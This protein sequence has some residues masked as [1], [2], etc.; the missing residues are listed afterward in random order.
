MK[1]RSFAVFVL[2]ALIPSAPL[3]ATMIYVDVGNTTPP[4]DGS[5]AN[6]YQFIRDGLDNAADG[7]TVAVSD[8]IYTG[9]K[10]RDLDFGDKAITLKSENGP[11]L[12][13]IDCGGTEAEPHRGFLFGPY[14]VQGQ[15][16]DGFTIRN[17]HADFGA[18]I[19]CDSNS[20]PTIR[21]C[22]V[23]ANT[24]AG[25]AGIYCEYDSS[26]TI[27]NCTITGNAAEG[28][29]GGIDCW[30]SDAT[31]VNCIIANNTA[32]WG[33]GLVDGAGNVS[34]LNCTITGNAVDHAGASYFYASESTV[35]N[36]ILWGNGLEEI[37]DDWATPTVTYCDVQGGTGEAWFGLGCID[38]DPLFVSGPLHDYYL[39]Q[40]AAG[41]GGDSPCVNAGSDTAAN[42]GLDA[43]TTRTDAVPDAG[44][45]DMGY[46]APPAVFGDVDGNLV[47]DG[48]DVTAVLTAWQTTPGHP[49]WNPAADLDGNGLIDG[50]DLTEVISNWTTAAAP[51]SEAAPT[52]GGSGDPDK[53]GAG[54]GNVRRGKGNVRYRQPLAGGH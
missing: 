9:T 36:S 3:V 11:D 47:V 42:L 54:R 29:G 27:I 37:V 53:P 51:A 45:V 33:G 39:S 18:G 14:D 20:S 50:L 25:G 31:I 2:L 19:F 6:P 12:T 13:I 43:L 17:G 16:L 23:T 5:A 41:Q 28:E 32:E 40:V 22:L 44:T 1:L 24:A 35:T 34:V 21:N 26:P 30:F 4:W 7:D 10:N 48:L 38:E 49:L 46:H 52:A 15:T 8:G